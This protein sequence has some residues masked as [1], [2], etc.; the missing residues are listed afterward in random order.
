MNSESGSLPHLIIDELGFD[1]S[2][3]KARFLAIL[4]PPS[5]SIGQGRFLTGARLCFGRLLRPSLNQDFQVNFMGFLRWR[6]GVQ[7]RV[8]LAA[9]RILG[10][11]MPFSL[12]FDLAPIC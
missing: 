5:L 6:E 9:P 10:G 4:K 3:V 12:C 7:D 2:S 11:K 1:P 8:Q